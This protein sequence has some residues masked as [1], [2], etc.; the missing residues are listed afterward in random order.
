MNNLEKPLNHKLRIVFNLKKKAEATEESVKTFL[1]T[2]HFIHG[3]YNNN[4]SFV[5]LNDHLKTLEHLKKKAGGKTHRFYYLAIPPEI[6]LTVSAQISHIATDGFVRLAIERPF[7]KDSVTSANLSAGLLKQFREDQ[8]FR[9]DHYL[10]KTAIQ[11]LLI[12]RFGNL[13]FEPL[14]N[15]ANIA[16]VQITFS[17][18]SGVGGYGPYFDHYG[19]IRDV[20]VNHLMQV[21]ALIC[22]EP[23]VTYN[24]NE[25][26]AEKRKVFTCY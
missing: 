24:A 13:V 5:E 15:R 19:I 22:M 20:M 12:L 26:R 23:P 21:L 4:K 11:N 9:I 25:I 16:S 3:D 8:I 6:F 14:W 2:I 7:G 10:G 17:E 1:Q 18:S